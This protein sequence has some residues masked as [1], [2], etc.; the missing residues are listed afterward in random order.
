MA[1]TKVIRF[2]AQ[3]KIAAILSA[4]VL[5]AAVGSLAVNGLQFGL[6]FTG[7]TQV[8]VGCEQPV[9]LGKVRTTLEQQSIRNT[10][11]VHFGTDVD[12]LI[13]MQGSLKE[14]GVQQLQQGLGQFGPA[15]T[16][17]LASRGINS[18]QYVE[19]L[20]VRD[21]P[22]LADNLAAL[23]PVAKYGTLH[24]EP[25]EEGALAVFLKTS[26]EE[27]VTGDLIRGLG[28]ATGQQAQLRRSE[29]VGPQVGEELRDDGGLGLLFALAVVMIYVALR[30]Q[31]K[32]S[33][34]AVAALVHDVLVVLGLFSFMHLD[35][36]LT[37]LAA[38]LAV[39]GYS[40]ND[41]IVV[42]DRIREN[43]R[44]VRKKGPQDIIDISL[45]QTLG[46]TLVTSATT[47]LVLLALFL[48][49]GELIRGFATALII[50]V[51]V[52]TYSSVYVVPNVLLLMNISKE[53]LIVPDK[54]GAELEEV[55]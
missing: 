41:T 3:R 22:G 9:E 49:G 7:G 42:S 15:A 8:E 34:G 43:F 50:G 18:D 2:M 33:V 6:D 24:S 12:V 38:V 29:F 1:E 45:T 30:F 31:F 21:A 10:S 40:L 47:L 39:I 35:F 16:I 55:P 48:V 36:D 51:L 25:A 28:Q 32:F 23:F 46:R 54:E 53:D 52:G 20:L 26:L 37:V 27:I 19:R 13:R 11:V 14:I 4:L 5:L 17:E 44:K